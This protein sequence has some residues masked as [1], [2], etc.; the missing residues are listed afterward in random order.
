MT[1]Q[2][3]WMVYWLTGMSGGSCST[4]SE[5]RAIRLAEAFSD[6][7]S[8]RGSAVVF[9]AERTTSPLDAVIVWEGGEDGVI[10]CR[11]RSASDGAP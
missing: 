4:D 9:F 7:T 2:G 3:Y 11:P 8:Y 10:T 6:A 1:E 5:A